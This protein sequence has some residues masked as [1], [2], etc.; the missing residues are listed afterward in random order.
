MPK[1]KILI[2]EDDAIT[3]MDMEN[4][5]KRLDYNVVGMVAYGEKAIEKV[6]ENTPDLVLMDIVLKGEM[7]GIEAAGEIHTQFDLPIIFLTAHADKERIERAKITMP[8]GFILKPFQNKDLKV[9][10][11]MALYVAKADTERK[12]T[13]ETLRESEERCRYNSGY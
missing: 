11:E 12:L 8:F 10:I 4:H 5:L 6:K 1:V 3:A 7:D 13:E 2:V 9:T